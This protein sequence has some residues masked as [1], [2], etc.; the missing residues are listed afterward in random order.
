[1]V[2]GLG[3]KGCKVHAANSEQHALGRARQGA[4]GFIDTCHALP[5]VTVNRSPGRPGKGNGFYAALSRYG[6]HVRAHLRGKGVGGI[7]DMGDALLGHKGG[8][9]ANTAKAANAGWQWL[10]FRRGNTTR[11]AENGGKLALGNRTGQGAGLRG[12][13][14]N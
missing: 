14:E 10:G 11:I 13:P 6:C 12:S 1:M 5:L 2:L 4:D 8:K 3:G 7:D 9:A